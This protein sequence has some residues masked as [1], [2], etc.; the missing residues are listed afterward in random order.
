MNKNKEQSPDE[1]D[2]HPEE[3]S[4]KE[5]DD[6]DTIDLHDDEENTE[7]GEEVKDK[8]EK[9]TD[10]KKDKK[11]L[12]KGLKS[13]LLYFLIAVLVGSFSGGGVYLWQKQQNKEVE[14]EPQEVETVSK[15]EEEEEEEEEEVASEENT[16][17]TTALPGLNLRKE[18]SL[19]AEII[20]ELPFRTK[21]IIEKEEGDWYYGSDEK[22]EKGYFAKAYTSKT[23]PVID[24]LT[25]KGAD[26]SASYPKDWVTKA[27]EDY[28]IGFGPDAESL[29]ICASEKGAMVDI[30]K[31]Q[32][33][34]LA[35]HIASVKN[36]LDSF[37][38]S[39]VTIDGISAIKISGVT[40]AAELGP[41]AGSTSISIALESGGQVYHISYLQAPGGVDYSSVFDSIAESIDFP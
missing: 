19:S 17:Y 16:I 18:A 6:D 13:F 12:S 37:T 3:L 30:V 15:I 26:Y 38:E 32:G 35:E 21:M 23:D 9:K 22:G 33:Q 25:Y 1:N 28:Y 2:I 29:Q 36:S 7:K 39:S 11:I 24:W 8:K 41:A 20:K 4:I 40:A 10:V 31:I 14:E 27:C 34:T 5:V